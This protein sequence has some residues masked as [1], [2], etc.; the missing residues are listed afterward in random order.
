V[1]M[2]CGRARRLLWPDAGPR[3]ATAEILEARE[4]AATCEGCTGFLADMQGMAEAIGRQAPRPTAPV[5]V[6]NRVFQAIARARATAVSHP[7]RTRFRQMIFAGVAALLVAGVGLLAYM[8]LRGRSPDRNAALGSIVEDRL[9]SQKG[10][11]LASAD[12]AQVAQWLAE[13]LPF[14]V[15]IPIFP[16]ARLT[17][18]RVL[19]DSR[20]SGG[21][22]EYTVGGRTLSYYVLQGDAAGLPGEIRL[23][24]TS[25]Y[26]V[27]SWDD[28]GL[29]HALVAAL[30]SARLIELAR[31]C[32]HQ[33][34]E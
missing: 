9:R 15:Q 11:G 20:R 4:H 25:G 14:A 21:V 3:K 30:P 22:V 7:R 5:E 34:M 18:A 12:S 26:R 1:T 32:I 31:Y 23:A 13:R 6:R 28:S 27:A 16:E 10:A 33:M 8:G 2:N 29:T 19:V 24:S 17:G